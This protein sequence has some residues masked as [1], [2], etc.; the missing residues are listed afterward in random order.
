MTQLTEVQVTTDR[1]AKVLTVGLPTDVFVPAE[2]VI[3][4]LGEGWN[5]PTR[6]KISCIDPMVCDGAVTGLL[7]R[8]YGPFEGG[9]DVDVRDAVTSFYEKRREQAPQCA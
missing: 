6:D 7:V 3:H 9:E 5:S 4:Y 2:E 1:W 8:F